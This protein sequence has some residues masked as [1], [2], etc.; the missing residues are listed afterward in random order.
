LLIGRR[1]RTTRY[2]V[3]FVIV[4]LCATILPT[5]LA[6]AS[7]PA[8][9]IYPNGGIYSSATI[10][11][12]SNIASGA[13]AYYTTNGSNPKT[14]SV[15]IA[16]TGAF[17]I[18]QS[19]TVKAAVY[20]PAEGWS[21]VVSASFVIQNQSKPE[22]PT[23]SPNGGAYDEAQ[24][25]TLGNIA[26]GDTAYY[27]TDGTNP[28]TSGT[29]VAY[30]GAFTISQSKTVKAATHDPSTGWSDMASASFV[31]D[32]ESAPEAPT[33]SPNGGAYDEAQSVTLGNIASGD[34]AYYTTDGT[35]PKT[36]GTSVAY[37]G[38]FTIDESAT[39]KAATHDPVNGWSS[40]ASA[41]FVIEEAGVE[42]PTI[43]PNGGAYDEAQSVTLGNIASGD[44]AYYTTDGSNPKTSSTSVAYTGAF[45]ISQS[46]TVKA[47]THDP[48]LGW[49]SI[50]S[51]SFSITDSIPDDNDEVAQLKEKFAKAVNKNQW[52]QAQQIL[53][54][55]RKLVE[56]GTQ[57]DQ[58]AELKEQ[59][60]DAV[61]N[62]Q[63]DEA[64]DLLKQIIKLENSDWA[65]E[66]LGQIYKDKGKKNVCVF[67][68]GNE[69]S[70]DVQ[71]QII[72]DRT[73]VP[74][75]K[76][77]NAL[78]V[79]DD[80][81]NWNPNGGV[82]TIKD[83]NNTIILQNNVTNIYLNGKSYETDVAPQIRDGRM[84]VPLR[85]V[86]EMFN[87]TVKWYPTGKIVSIS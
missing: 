66:Q 52:K 43:N 12:L 80:N 11:T 59:L 37:T 31:I 58:L 51:A 18:S 15:A 8:P 25:V 26:S 5:G 17:T 21:S 85:A 70:F 36:S 54:Q 76:I 67:A 68:K 83:G 82:V 44:T 24:S 40:I 84:L 3:L 86:S 28:K 79:S 69:L 10:V 47:A 14:S 73:M 72:N 35:N 32:I 4:A 41:S 46:K 49:S 1:S 33:I 30:T 13:T 55:I 7:V 56:K 61:N 20:D 57:E 77:G 65:Y 34:T 64:E 62:N 2:T 22:A 9:T 75:R 19:S 29:S 60:I 78:G 38:T 53:Q 48:V 42:A 81:I 63:W 6:A 74:V 71:P 50:A 87:H 39:V 27:T 45:T 23:I 16:F